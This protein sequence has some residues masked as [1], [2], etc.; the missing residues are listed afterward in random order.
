V[1]VLTTIAQVREARAAID[2][3]V[4]LVPTMGALHEG[5]LALVRAARAANE[6]VFVSIF[7]NPTQFGPNE[8]FAAYPR[9]TER[10]LDLLRAADVDFAFMPSPEEIYPPGFDTAVDAGSIAQPLE[11]AHRPGHFLGVATVVLKLLNVVR[12]ARAYFGRKDAQQLAVIR[13]VVR[14]LDLDVEIVP[15]E[16]VREPDGLAMS[17][18]NAYLSPAER[19]S[20]LVLWNALTLA[21]EMWTRGARDAEAFRKR[22][23]ELIEE[24]ESARI[25]YVS[26]ADPET[27]REVDRIQGPVLVSLAVRI[28]RTRLIDNITLGANNREQRTDSRLL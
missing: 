2:G 19:Q 18:R 5:H 14:D 23:R 10:D 27:L 17:S 12:P 13:H 3:S 6:R 15:V 22:M 7:V 28:G 20:A 25:D 26:V 16:T 1:Q 9:N 4:G 24:E 11:G 21:R 8:D